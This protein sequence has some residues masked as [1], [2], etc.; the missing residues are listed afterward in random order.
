MVF[1]DKFNVHLDPFLS[2]A[3]NVVLNNINIR[4]INEYYYFTTIY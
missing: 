1:S 3:N 4:S 2:C